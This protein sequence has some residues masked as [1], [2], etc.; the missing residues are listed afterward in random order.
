MTCEADENVAEMGS[1]IGDALSDSLA[2]FSDIPLCWDLEEENRDDLM[3]PTSSDSKIFEADIDL[4]LQNLIGGLFLEMTQDD[5]V[6]K[7]RDETNVHV[8]SCIR[9]ESASEIEPLSLTTGMALDS[10][11]KA[12]QSARDVCSLQE[13]NDK[14]DRCCSVLGLEAK[15]SAESIFQVNCESDPSDAALFISTAVLPSNPPNSIFSE[16][17]VSEMSSEM[18]ASS[19]ASQ[20]DSEDETF[21]L[22]SPFLEPSEDSKHASEYSPSN[23]ADSELSSEPE[24]SNFDDSESSFESESLDDDDSGS[25]SESES[26]SFDDS[27]S[28]SE[29]ESS[30]LDQINSLIDE[31]ILDCPIGEDLGPIPEE[32]WEQISDLLLRSM[33]E[34]SPFS[35]ESPLSSH[36]KDKGKKRWSKLRKRWSERTSKRAAIKLNRSKRRT[37]SKLLK[38]L[39]K[40]AGKKT[41]SVLSFFVKTPSTQT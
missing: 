15:R 2:S 8:F 17:V 22:K 24:S 41:K 38:R 18:D 23:S 36:S 40:W 10:V 37:S 9:E 21:L 29:S 19:H 16:N 30:D 27:E 4:I 3:E 13:N 12:M 6:G 20:F 11:S 7:E 5:S 28:F 31:Q 1:S 34:E 14:A 25:F 32:N 26:S 35:Q 39:R 33:G